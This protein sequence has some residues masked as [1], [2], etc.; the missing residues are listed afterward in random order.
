VGVL[1]T[2]MSGSVADIVESSAGMAVEGALQ[3]A[4]WVTLG[5]ALYD[6]FG[7]GRKPWSVGDLPD[8]PEEEDGIRIS[9]SSSIVEI[10]LSVF[11]AALFIIMITRGEWFLIIMQNKNVIIPFSDAA[12][13][14]LL[15]YIALFGALGVILNSF[16]L[17][18]AR[19]NVKLCI[20]NIIQNIIWLCAALYIL[21]W[22][23][24]LRYEFVSFAK[25][26]FDGESDILVFIEAGGIIKFFTFIFI[27]A[28]A[29]DIGV[30][31]RNTWKSS[32]EPAKS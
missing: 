18:W 13:G 8:L 22:P 10:A 1:M 25:S 19:W 3:A 32:R 23:D 16:K 27:V 29:I 31:I 6:H 9:R 14:R 30:S 12:L 26:L 2:F 21:R 17:Y 20:I 28:A 15:P 24:L 11:F 5:F 4:F 7:V